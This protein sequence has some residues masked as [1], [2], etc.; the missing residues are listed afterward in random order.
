MEEPTNKDTSEFNAGISLLIQLDII[1]KSMIEAK[2]RKPKNYQDYFDTVDAYFMTLIGELNDK[3]TDEQL[4]IQ[5][6]VKNNLRD[7]IDK[8]NKG[9]PIPC[10]LVES[11][12]Q[13][14]IELRKL[15]KKLGMGMPK[16]DDERDIPVLSRKPRMNYR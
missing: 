10:S 6:E 13:W 12:D 4:M 16:K 9:L 11:I 14:Q 7:I 5:K 2:T 15:K 8:Q 1:E 3:D